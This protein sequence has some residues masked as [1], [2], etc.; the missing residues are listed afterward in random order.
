MRM[1]L[2]IGNRYLGDDGAG[3]WIASSF[4]HP[5]WRVIDCS[6]APENFTSVV[7]REHPKLLV[8]V[9]AADMGISPGDFRTI[10]QD[11]VRDVSIGTHQMP[12]SLLM[13]YL[14]DAA[15][16]ILFVGIQP[17]RVREGEGLSEPVE[18]GA[19]R[20][21]ALLTE[22]RLQDLIPLS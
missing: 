3:V 10:R 6:T 18:R 1:L 8:L 22:D 13:E 11:Q 20:L 19:L 9:D 17:H 4:H 16:T 12:L 15:D 21:I 14:A 2:G 5:G 7:R